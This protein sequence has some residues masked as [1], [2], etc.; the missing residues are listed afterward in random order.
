[1]NNKHVCAIGRRAGNEG[2]SRRSG[3][4]TSR[5]EAEG[6]PPMKR[7]HGSSMTVRYRVVVEG[8]GLWATDMMARRRF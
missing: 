8:N 2:K 1:M 5:R 3:C 7:A 6:R 4:V